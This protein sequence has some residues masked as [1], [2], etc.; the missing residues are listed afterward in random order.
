MSLKV[1]AKNQEW[2]PVLNQVFLYSYDKIHFLVS[3]HHTAISGYVLHMF[4]LLTKRL[5]WWQTFLQW[6]LADPAIYSE[7]LLSLWFQL[8]LLHYSFYILLQ[9][10]CFD[11]LLNIDFMKSLAV[12]YHYH[13]VSVVI[14][15]SQFLFCGFCCRGI[16]FTHGL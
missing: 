3:R 2:Y 11:A 13:R 7:S 8:S 10:L 5:Y 15:F 12:A 1:G 14:I 4:V 16:Q 9:L 6:R